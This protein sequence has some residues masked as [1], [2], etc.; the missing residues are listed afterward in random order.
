MDRLLGQFMRKAPPLTILNILLAV[1]ELAGVGG[2]AWRGECPQ[3]VGAGGP[4]TQHQ[5]GLV[6]AVLRQAPA[7]LPGP[8]Q[9]MPR[10]LR[11]PLV[12]RLGREAVAAMEAQALPP[13][14]DLT[15]RAGFAAPEGLALPTA[16]LRL[17]EAA[18]VGA[19]RLCRRRLVGAGCRRRA[20]GALAGRGGGPAGAGP[21]CGAG[22]AR[23]C[24]WPLPGPR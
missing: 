14:V 19:A 5:A 16:R 15:L 7:L 12:R 1:V 17:A 9:K 13:P 21:V 11:Q 22:G 20:G 2:P 4:E 24:N 18:G 10:R 6:N 8:A 3:R 23:P